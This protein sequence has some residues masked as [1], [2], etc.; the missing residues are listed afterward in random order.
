MRMQLIQPMAKKF[1]FG[2]LIMYLLLM[3][4]VRSWQFLRMMSVTMNLLKR[5]IYQ[6]NQLLKVAIFQKQHIQKMAHISILSF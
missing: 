3:E 1:Q 6:S 4:Q 5:L 2:L